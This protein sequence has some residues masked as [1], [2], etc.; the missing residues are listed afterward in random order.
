MHVLTMPSRAEALQRDE[1]FTTG[2]RKSGTRAT[3]DD[4]RQEL[5]QRVREITKDRF[6]D[7]IELGL[8]FAELNPTKQEATDLCLKSYSTCK[9][10]I[11]IAQSEFITAL[12]CPT[13]GCCHRRQ[14]PEGFKALYQI[15]LC[16]PHTSLKRDLFHT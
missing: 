14:M 12:N 2:Y 4:R 9:K 5:F 3:S 13:C 10:Y 11:N 6:D 16:T 7:V 1:P 15:Y 8:L